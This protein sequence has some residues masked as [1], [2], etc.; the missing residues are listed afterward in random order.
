L[1]TI[2]LKLSKRIEI[3]DRQFDNKRTFVTA[4]SIAFDAAGKALA[5]TVAID[6]RFPAT[7]AL[8]LSDSF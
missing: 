1:L 6:E 5:I 7:V 8:H 2:D 3:F 4:P